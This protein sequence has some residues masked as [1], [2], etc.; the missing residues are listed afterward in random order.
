MGEIKKRK[1]FSQISSGLSAK[2]KS[3]YSRK[4]LEAERSSRVIWRKDQWTKEKVWGHFERKNSWKA[5]KGKASKM[6][7]LDSRQNKVSWG[8]SSKTNRR[9]TTCKTKKSKGCPPRRFS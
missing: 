4:H 2:W 8:N 1:R 6:S 5:R 9:S 3:N 7:N